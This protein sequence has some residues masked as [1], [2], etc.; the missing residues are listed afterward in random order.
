MNA[1]AP[2]LVTGL[3]LIVAIGAQNAFVLRQGLRRE[4][5]GMVVALC[6]GCDVALILLGVRGIGTVAESYPM[7]LDL[8]RWG[9]AAYLTWFALC[10][11]RAALR[12]SGLGASDLD[13]RGRRRVARTTL[14]LTLLNPHVYLDTVVMLGSIANQHGDQGRWWFAG[15]AVL[16]SVLWFSGIGFGATAAARWLNRPAVWRAIDGAI[17]VVMLALAWRLAAG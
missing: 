7:A 9:G 16:G 3:S 14:T 5:V 1:F 17:G 15:G 6:A 10:S 13:R 12:P 11:I 8:L 2:G 4:H